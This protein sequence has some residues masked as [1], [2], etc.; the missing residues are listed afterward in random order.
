MKLSEINLKR[1]LTLSTSLTIIFI[2]LP[3]FAELILPGRCPHMGMCWENKFLKKTLLEKGRDGT[4][5]SVELAGRSWRIE[6]QP[7]DTFEPTRTSYVYCSKTRPAFIFKT[8]GKFIAHLLNPGGDWYGYNQS[9]YPVYWATCHNFVGP[10]FFS[11][12]MKN[13]AIQ[14]GYPLNLPS[15]QMDLNNVRDILK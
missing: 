8:D 7:P 10:D 15:E 3:A 1:L 14:L 13:R 9:D 11:E 12:V 6:S 2:A 5:Y 4:L